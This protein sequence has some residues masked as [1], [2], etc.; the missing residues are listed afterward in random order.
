MQPMATSVLLRIFLLESSLA[1]VEPVRLSRNGW[2]AV[3][4]A[5]LLMV[6]LGGWLWHRTSRQRWALETA[7]P[8]ITRLPTLERLWIRSTGEV[9]IATDPSGAE[10]SFRPYRGDPNAW[11]TVGQTPLQKIRLAQGDYVWRVAKPGFATV[12]FI[13]S[14]AVV[15]P[16]GASSVFDY[17]LKLRPAA[18]VPPRDGCSTWWAG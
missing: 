8:E 13:D 15:P 16:P 12:L 14:P 7:A 1:P 5:T 11:E 9:S 4:F 10:V 18:S 6:I 17:A 2:I 3:G